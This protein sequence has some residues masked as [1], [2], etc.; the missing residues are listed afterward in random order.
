M[1]KKPAPKSRPKKQKVLPPKIVFV[2]GKWYNEYGKEVPKPQKPAPIFEQQ[3]APAPAPVQAPAL[4]GYA[5]PVKPFVRFDEK[6][7]DGC[8]CAQPSRTG[9]VPGC[10]HYKTAVYNC[11]PALPEDLERFSALR[12]TPLDRLQ[13][14]RLTHQAFPVTLDKDEAAREMERRRRQCMTDLIQTDVPRRRCWVCP[15]WDRNKTVTPF[16][17]QKRPTESLDQFPKALEDDDD[18]LPF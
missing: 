2:G 8:T 14:D 5:P 13:F 18:D 11:E 16:D 1:K 7:I 15:Y 10:A 17:S 9:H 4:Q 6:R 12:G 3:Q